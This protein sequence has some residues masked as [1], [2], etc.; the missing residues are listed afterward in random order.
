MQEKF[1]RL[2]PLLGATAFSAST[3]AA[4]VL[5]NGGFETGN[6]SGWVASTNGVGGC[7][8]D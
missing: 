1:V 6:F 8:T 3:H 5:T 7:D 4:Q 2:L